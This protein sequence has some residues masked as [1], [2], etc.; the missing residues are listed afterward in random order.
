MARLVPGTGNFQKFRQPESYLAVDK[1]DNPLL[2]PM[3]SDDPV[4]SIRLLLRVDSDSRLACRRFYGKIVHFIPRLCAWFVLLAGGRQYILWL[5]P[6]G[7][8]VHSF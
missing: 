7:F 2:R 3:V 5:L 4:D 8:G 6:R 1:H